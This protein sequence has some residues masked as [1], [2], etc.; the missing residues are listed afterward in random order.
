[1]KRY[2]FDLVEDETTLDEDGVLLID[3]EAVRSHA[4]RTGCSILQDLARE[5]SQSGLSIRVRDEEGLEVHR[6]HFLCEIQEAA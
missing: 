4:I 2:F 6:M 5:R 3:G 1:M